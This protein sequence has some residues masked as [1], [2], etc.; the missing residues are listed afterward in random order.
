M[1]GEFFHFAHHCRRCHQPAKSPA[2]H[3]E[4]LGKTVHHEQVIGGGHGRMSQ[5]SAGFDAVTEPL[6]DF[7][8]D[9]NALVSSGAG[10]QCSNFIHAEQGASRVGRCG[11]HQ[12][13]GMGGPHR[14]DL[15]GRGLIVACRID[16][17]CHCTTF[18]SSHQ[19]SIGRVARIGQQPFVARIGG[20]RQGEQ[21]GGGSASSDDDPFRADVDAETLLVIVRD[22]FTQRGQAEA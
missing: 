19:M 16:R 17:K 7:I 3:A 18:K 20:C 13:A 1:L 4:I 11:H 6:I 15:D 22:R 8:D 2:G 21:Q 12:A 14:V 9:E 10:V 5:C